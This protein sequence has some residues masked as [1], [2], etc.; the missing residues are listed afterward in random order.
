MADLKKQHAWKGQGVRKNM[1]GSARKQWTDVAEAQGL[2]VGA[3]SHPTPRYFVCD[4]QNL[5]AAFGVGCCILHSTDERAE[6][7]RQALLASGCGDWSHSTA[8]SSGFLLTHTLVG[9]RT[10]LGSLG[11]LCARGRPTL[12][13]RLPAT[14]WS[15]RDCGEH[16]GHEPVCRSSLSASLSLCL[17]PLNK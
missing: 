8:C 10:W 4:N 2:F 7:R 14:A 11:L 17:C 5:T 12:S 13:S 3:H 9:N 15:S 1:A 16:L 6:A